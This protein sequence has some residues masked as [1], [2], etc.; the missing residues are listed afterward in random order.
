[1]PCSNFAKARVQQ[2]AVRREES[3]S[4]KTW[5]TLKIAV[6]QGKPIYLYCGEPGYFANSWLLFR[7]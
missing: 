7:C 1:M 3:A 4:Y 6:W 2:D 5:G